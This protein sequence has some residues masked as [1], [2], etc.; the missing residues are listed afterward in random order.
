M[1]VSNMSTLLEGKARETLSVGGGLIGSCSAAKW[2]TLPLWGFLH[3]LPQL[4]SHEQDRS[5]K[6]Y[7][8][9]IKFSQMFSN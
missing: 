6:K 5:M 2:A 3:A 9:V 1:L 4:H 8:R 7:L